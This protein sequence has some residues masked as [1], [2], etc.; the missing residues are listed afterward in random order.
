[1]TTTAEPRAGATSPTRPR[2]SVGFI[3]VLGVLVALGPFTIDLYLPALPTIERELHTTSA[4]VQLTLTGTLAGLAFGQLV[5][6]PVSDAIGRRRPLLAGLL[7]HVLASLACVL[8]PGVV[9][10]GV[11]RVLQGFGAAAA[12]VIAIAVV[13][14]LFRGVRA[15]RMISRLILV[16]GASPVLAPTVGSELLRWTDWRGIF[17]ALALLGVGVGV[18]AALRLPETLPPERRQSGGVRGT[19]RAY[20]AL[21]GDRTFLALV[22]VAALM[23]SALFAYVAG[24]SF[25]LQEQFG[26]SEQMFGVVFA[27]NS[28]ALIGAAQ[29]NVWLLGRWSSAQILVTAVAVAVLASVALLVLTV[30]EVGGVWGVLVPLFVVLGGVGFAGPNASALGLSLH[31]E[32]AGTAAALL[33]AAQFGLGALTAPVVGVLGNDGVAMA[34]VIGGSTLLAAITLV[35]VLRLPVLHTID[36]TESDAVVGH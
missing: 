32:S 7:V 11:L 33:G 18:V 16:I 26:F 15:A 25:V 27:V 12:S 4:A 20:A 1:M 13:R 23:M 19:G 3:L 28:V 35:G 2:D 24:S 14:D 17:A 9:T 6:G 30:A 22:L 36:T 31:G 5:L 21:L 34:L 29:V 8:A 10:L